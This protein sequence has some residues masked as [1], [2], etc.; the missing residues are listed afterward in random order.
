VT[1]V[2]LER[3]QLGEAARALARAFQAAPSPSSLW[4]DPA[5]RAR[6]LRHFMSIPLAD[7]LAHG[8]VDALVLDGAIA[9][10][11]AWYPAGAYPMGR[12][13]ELR[14]TPRIL[15][16]AAAAPRSLGRLAR[17]GTAIEAAF[18]ADRPAYLAVIGVAPEAQGGGHGTALL[19]AGLARTGGPCYLET[20]TA[21]AA[22]LY[23][24]IGFRTLEADVQL[25]PD[26]PTH[27]RM[28]RG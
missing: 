15:G 17:F 2:P 8:H 6:A 11:A 28:L 14:A 16:A 24:R 4:P 13:R 3:G 25:L 20:D 27:W 1:V 9:G 26:G 12:R 22:R 7:A 21:A 23:E 5:R 10:A 18:P 19:E